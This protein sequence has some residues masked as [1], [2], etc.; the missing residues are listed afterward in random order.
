MWHFNKSSFNKSDHHVP[1]KSMRAFRAMASL[2]KECSGIFCYGWMLL[3]KGKG[4]ALSYKHFMSEDRDLHHLGATQE[5]RPDVIPSV[6][7]HE[8]WNLVTPLLTRPL[9]LPSFL[10]ISRSSANR[11]H[12]FSKECLTFLA[13]SGPTRKHRACCQWQKW[14]LSPNRST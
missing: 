5:S 6:C 12:T 14:M 1:L 9:S 4:N 13:L 7:R 10:S 8:L 11:R 2:K 3:Y